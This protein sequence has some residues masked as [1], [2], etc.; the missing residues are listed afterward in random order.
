VTL[1][2]KFDAEATFDAPSSS[3]ASRSRCW[4]RR[5]STCMMAHPRWPSADLSSLRDLHRLDG[6][7]RTAHRAVHARGVPLI[8]VW[9][10]TETAPI[11][12]CL[13]ADE[14]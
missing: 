13:H 6:R 5:S 3:S 2:A 1:H 8:Q 11:A 14:A 9:G 12:A 10:A 4:C 7:T